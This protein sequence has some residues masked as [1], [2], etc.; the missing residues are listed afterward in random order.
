MSAAQIEQGAAL[1][2]GVKEEYGGI[3]EGAL[4]A[5]NPLA[6][7]VGFGQRAGGNHGFGGVTVV[8]ELYASQRSQY[9]SN[10]QRDQ[11][12]ENTLAHFHFLFLPYLICRIRRRNGMMQ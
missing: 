1:N 10:G 2:A 4:Q 11:L 3:A 12:N 7:H 8:V 6:E 5:G 9:Q